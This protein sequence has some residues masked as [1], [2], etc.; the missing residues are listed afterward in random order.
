MSSTSQAIQRGILEEKHLKDAMAI[1]EE[2]QDRLGWEFDLGD[3]LLIQGRLHGEDDRDLLHELRHGESPPLDDTGA[4]TKLH[5]RMDMLGQVAIRLGYAKTREIIEAMS[6]QA[7]QRRAGQRTPHLGQVL[8][9]RGILTEEQL[10]ECLETQKEWGGP[11]E[12]TRG[13]GKFSRLDAAFWEVGTTNFEVPDDEISH[14]LDWLPEVGPYL[15]RRVSLG[16]ALVI[17]WGLTCEQHQE[18]IEKFRKQVGLEFRDVSIPEIAVEMGCAEA[19]DMS[20]ALRERD[21]WIQK[22]L[23][24]PSLESVLLKKRILS[25]EEIRECIFLQNVKP[26]RPVAPPPPPPP[27][28]FHRRIISAFLSWLQR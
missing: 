11:E 1:R 21:R 9:D 10:D 4:V 7:E 2:I 23:E 13:R 12:R 18:V 24:V 27:P 25:E 22:G 5:I 28:P 15:S 8:V 6:D 26:P 20:L 16:Q 14:L 17:R 19:Q 3:I